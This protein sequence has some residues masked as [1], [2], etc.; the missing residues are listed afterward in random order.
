VDNS[1]DLERFV[2]AQDDYGSY[3]GALAELRAG[4]KTGH[5][6]WYVFPQ[7]AGLGLSAISQRYAIGSL[8]EAQAYLRHEVLG[9]RLRECASVVA[10]T[11]DRT[12]EQIFGDLDAVKVRSCVTLFLRAD[13]AEAVF[14]QVLDNHYGGVPDPGTDRRLGA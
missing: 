11:R 5:W 8:A 14:Q 1:Y 13:P 9:P 12:A 3:D 4:R 6:I 2:A 10:A 7:I